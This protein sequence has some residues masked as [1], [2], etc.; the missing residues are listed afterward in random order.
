METYV[1]EMKKAA[2]AHA[3]FGGIITT[4]KRA[5]DNYW[6]CSRILQCIR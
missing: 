3:D 5:Q 4:L 1:P 2:L 6:E